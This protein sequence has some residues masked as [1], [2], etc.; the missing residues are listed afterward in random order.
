MNIFITNDDG[1][2]AQGIAVLARAAAGFGRVTLVAP[3]RQCSAMSHRITLGKPLRL[4]AVDFPVE[5]VTAYSLE[6]TPADCVKAALDAILPE[7][8]DVVLSGI[9][10]G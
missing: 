6:G 10:H 1:I 5:N 8:P 9:H 2:S 7:R 3:A 4:E